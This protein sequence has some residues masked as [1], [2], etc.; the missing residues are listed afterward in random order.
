MGKF[1]CSGGPDDQPNTREGDCFGIR[2]TSE[3]EI[4]P[5]NEARSRAS[6]SLSDDG[7]PLWERS[8][9]KMGRYRLTRSE[10][11]IDQ[12]E[13]LL[14]GDSPM[15]DTISES[16]SMQFEEEEHDMSEANGTSSEAE[17]ISSEVNDTLS[18]ID[19]DMDEAHGPSSDLDNYLIGSLM[20]PGT[21]I[22]AALSG[23][24]L[25]C[26]EMDEKWEFG[27]V[28]VSRTAMLVASAFGISVFV[29]MRTVRSEV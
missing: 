6:S 13:G 26:G 10:S 12:D 14:S 19:S 16:D 1:S 2:A 22:S 27:L 3:A 4:W 9:L 5:T 28:I 20:K 25:S 24:T 18:E 15:R 29:E 17:S 8:L 23:V 7:L 21:H 11:E